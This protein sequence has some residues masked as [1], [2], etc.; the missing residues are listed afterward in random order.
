MER[1]DLKQEPRK[2]HR[3]WPYLRMEKG[4]NHTPEP[5]QQLL[6]EVKDGDEESG[7]PPSGPFWSDDP[8]DP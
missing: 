6:V 7:Q 1:F 3:A 8:Q 2:A 5:A 4:A